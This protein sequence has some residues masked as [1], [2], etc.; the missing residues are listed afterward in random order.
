MNPTIV[1]VGDRGEGPEALEGA[2][3]GGIAGLS[4]TLSE[5]IISEAGRR[6]FFGQDFCGEGHIEFGCIEA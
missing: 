2:E 1:V 5:D 3:P 6:K 4:R